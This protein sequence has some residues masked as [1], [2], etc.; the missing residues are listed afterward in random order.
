MTELARNE[1]IAEDILAGV[2]DAGGEGRVDFGHTEELERVVENRAAVVERH[3]GVVMETAEHDM[4]VEATE[5]GDVSR[6]GAAKSLR[7]EIEE[8]ALGDIGAELVTDAM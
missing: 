7:I 5:A 2:G 6:A 3:G 4:A 1:A 8:M